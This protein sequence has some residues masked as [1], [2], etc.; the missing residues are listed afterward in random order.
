MLNSINVIALTSGH[1]MKALYPVIRSSCMSGD[2]A[3]DYFKRNSQIANAYLH[4]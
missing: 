3:G 4:T 1:G 2:K